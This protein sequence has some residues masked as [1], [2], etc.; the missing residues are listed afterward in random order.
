MLMVWQRRETVKV[1]SLYQVSEV[2]AGDQKVVEESRKGLQGGPRAPSVRLLFGDV[3]ATPAVLEFLED[4]R[5][6]R[7][8]GRILLAGGLEVDEEKMDEVVLWAPGEEEGSGISESEEEE[9]PG[10]PLSLVGPFP[11]S[12]FC[13]SI[14][15]IFIW[16]SQGCRGSRCPTMTAQAGAG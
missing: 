8:P 16:R 14:F 13:F 1:P 3:R 9:G 5:V 4:T 10:P 15:V 7:M 12:S 6:G 2:G 11:L